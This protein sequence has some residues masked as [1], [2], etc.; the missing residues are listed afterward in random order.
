[1]KSTVGLPKVLMYKATNT[2]KCT[3]SLK[4]IYFRNIFEIV[5]LK[6]MILLKYSE[7]NSVLGKMLGSFLKY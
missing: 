5:L 6:V 4:Q 7:L 1:M 3:K 2:L